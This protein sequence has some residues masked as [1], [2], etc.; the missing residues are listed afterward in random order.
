M[1][2][3]KSRG[4]SAT[5]LTLLQFNAAVDAV[6]QAVGDL[7]E[8]QHCGEAIRPQKRQPCASI[9]EAK[10]LYS[11]LDRLADEAGQPLPPDPFAA[12][13]GDWWEPTLRA[14]TKWNWWEWWKEWRRWAERVRARLAAA[15]ATGASKGGGGR[16]PASRKIGRPKKTEKDSATKVVAALSAHHGY[17][18][19]MSITNRQ[20][21]TNRGLAEKY[22]LSANALSRFLKDQFPEDKSPHRRYEAACRK[23]NIG[24]LLARWLRE[25][26]SRYADLLPHESGR[27][28]D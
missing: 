28:D 6:Q 25:A 5:V 4:S 11:Q 8:G 23:G 12:E 20:P 3:P 14:Q 1:S 19:G 22:G 16:R 13:Y 9:D 26:P 18:E 2:R 7:D 27:E 17:G 21:A 24:A 10:N 15:E